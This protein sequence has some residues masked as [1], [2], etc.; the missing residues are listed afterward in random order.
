MPNLDLLNLP[1]PPATAPWAYV[2]VAEGC[3]RSCGFCA[4][5][6]FRGPQRSRTVD[7]IL[8]EVDAL[9]AQEI[10]LVAQDLAA[11]GRDRSW[12]AAAG[13]LDGGRPGAGGSC[14]LSRR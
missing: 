11:Y 13:A 14:R 7:S 4:I 3:D 9:G 8:A 5:P 2:K 10:V 6:S 12:T 1:R